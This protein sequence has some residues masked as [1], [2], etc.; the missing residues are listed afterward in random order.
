MHI[1]HTQTTLLRGLYLYARDEKRKEM[2]AEYRKKN[3]DKKNVNN[4]QFNN[5]ITMDC[6][7]VEWRAVQSNC[8]LHTL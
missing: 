8:T 2:N 7:R 3:T 5:S 4:Q 1:A 6:E